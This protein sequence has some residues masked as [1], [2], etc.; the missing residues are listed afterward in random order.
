MRSVLALGVEV[1]Q[2]QDPIFFFAVWALQELKQRDELL[3]GVVTIRPMDYVES[4]QGDHRPVLASP[5]ALGDDHR[6][7]R[8]SMGQ[9][10]DTAEGSRRS[11]LRAA[12]GHC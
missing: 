11:L 4:L 3:S 9:H 8:S 2:F 6:L 5:G 7:S 1:A 12:G 10:G